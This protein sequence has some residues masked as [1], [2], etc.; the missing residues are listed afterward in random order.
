MSN[1]PTVIAVDLGGT[2]LRV[3]AVQED[4]VVVEKEKYDADSRS[5]CNSVLGCVAQSVKKMAEKIK[6][7]SDVIKGV[8]L[9]FPGIVDQE[10][11]IVYQSPHFPDWKDLNILDFFK[12]EIFWPLVID[13][14]ANMAAL[15]ESWKGAGQ[16]VK[17]FVMLTFGTGVGGGI[18]LNGQIFRGD[19]GFA[20]EVGHLCIETE[21]PRCACGSKGC[22]E[23][24]VSAN[25]IRRLVEFTDDPEGLNRLIERIGGNIE[26]VTVRYLH[27]AALDGDIFANIV[28]KKMGYYLGTGLASLTNTL[29]VE[30]FILGGGV[31]E[32]WNFFIEPARKELLERTYHEIASH[33]QI[34]KAILGDNA[35]LVGGASHFFKKS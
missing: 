31:S 33:I 4:G 1:V 27:E 2:H 24:Y 21:G 15:G 17:N 20:G 9:G 14:D 6:A 5:G 18:I 26:R 16:G 29:G 28:F 30:T 7:R 8:A 35:G 32:A 25:G 3:G 13:N 12:K 19:R 22:L 34:K 10:K 11:G 23:M